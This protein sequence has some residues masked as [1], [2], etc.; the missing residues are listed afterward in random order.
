MDPWLD[1]SPKKLEN[2]PATGSHRRENGRVKSKKK[3]TTNPAISSNFCAVLCPPFATGLPLP[4]GGTPG[5][6]TPARLRSSTV[7]AHPRKVGSASASAGAS[8]TLRQGWAGG[9]WGKVL[10]STHCSCQQGSQ[11][12]PGMCHST[13]DTGLRF[14]FGPGPP[15]GAGAGGLGGASFWGSG[16]LRSP[17]PRPRGAE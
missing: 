4:Q 9:G 3:S 17:L 2:R 10:P 12:I 15:T 6:V 11:H 16:P 8:A 14:F 1:I 13:H 7:P 5:S